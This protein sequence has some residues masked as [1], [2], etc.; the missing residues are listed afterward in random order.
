MR[1]VSKM[2]SI[3]LQGKLIRAISCFMWYKITECP[4]RMS[5]SRLVTPFA[6]LVRSACLFPTRLP[7]HYRSISRSDENGLDNKAT[8]VKRRLF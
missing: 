7:V 2:D 4:F 1:S 8:F 3:N 5:G 6:R